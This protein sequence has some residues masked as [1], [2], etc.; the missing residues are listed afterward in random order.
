MKFIDSL[1]TAFTSLKTNKTRSALTMLGIVIGISSVV[2]MVSLGSGA[3]NLIVGQIVDM[4]S[5]TIFVEPGAWSEK[6]EKGTM[7]ESMMEEFEI[8]TLTYGDA[9][10]I[11]KL[12]LIETTAPAVVGIGRVVYKDVTRKITFM[13]GSPNINEINGVYPN[14]GRMYTQDE[15]KTRARVA[16]LGYKIK[17]ELFGDQDPIGEIVRIKKTNFRIIGVMEERGTEMFLTLDDYIFVPLTTAQ[18]D[19]LG[20]SYIRWIAAKA[21]NEDVIDQAVEEI[22]LTLRERHNINNPEADP[23]KDDFKVMSQKETVEMLNT[24][25]YIFTIFLSCVAAI[26]LVVGGIGIMNIMLVSVTERTREIGLRKAVGARKKDILEQF[27]IEAVLLTIIG[28]TIGIILGV[29]GAFVGGIIIGNL[30]EAQWVF[31]ISIKAIAMAFSVSA[32]IGL[33]FGI[34]PARKAAKLNPIEALRYE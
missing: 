20:I 6:M 19:L 9:Q 18:K 8:K 14:S 30:L 25:T 33:I 3:Q 1:Q 10:A 24:I 11:E 2:A 29:V 27:L 34:F 32:A 31:S 22:R 7:M 26:A 16:V 12:S 5:N 23:A 17:E 21:I 15:L 4:G 13:G 28:G